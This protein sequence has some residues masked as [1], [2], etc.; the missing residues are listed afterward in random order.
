MAD[1]LA[2]DVLALDPRFGPLA[3]ATARI[4]QLPLDWLLTY[5]IDTVPSEWLPELGRQ[6][7]IM[8]LEGWQFAQTDAERRRLIRESIK[9]HRKK[10]TPWAVK[11]ALSMI[12]VEADLIERRDVRA[13]Y[14]AHNPLLLDGSWRLDGNGHALKPVDILSGLPY[15]EHWATFLVRINLDLARGYD[16]DE[17]RA[18]IR[19]WAPVARHPVLF[20][21]LAQDYL[22]PLASVYRLLLDKRVCHPYGWP[23]VTLHGCPNRAWRLGRQ[24]ALDGRPF[25]FQL[26]ASLTPTER[27]RSRRAASH[28]A[29]SKACASRVWSAQRLPAVRTRRLDGRWHLGGA[30]RIGRFALD[31]R[32]LTHARFSAATN[33]LPV[34]GRWRLGGP[35]TPLFEMRTTH[36]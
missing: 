23:G 9:L 4:E 17:V 8:P 26:G 24:A 16:M 22:Q 36:V 21:W 1:R 7:H 12:G 5:L 34:S 15:I 29:I 3:E 19:E 6:F 20:Y 28:A 30:P 33:S 11:R 27:I 18:A 14:I 10:G 32:R 35:M 31:G 25:G 13:A 2:P